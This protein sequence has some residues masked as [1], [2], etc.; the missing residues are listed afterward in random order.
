M[1]RRESRLRG[2]KAVLLWDEGLSYPLKHICVCSCQK[3]VVYDSRCLYMYLA[4]VQR[5]GRCDSDGVSQ[6]LGAAG[7]RTDLVSIPFLETRRI[8]LCSGEMIECFIYFKRLG[9]V[10]VKMLCV[11]ASK[12]TAVGLCVGVTGQLWVLCGCLWTRLQDGNKSG[13]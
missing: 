2:R 9:R 7:S 11:C 5:G 6:C 8:I 4:V 1:K 3:D 10:G 12:R 13:T